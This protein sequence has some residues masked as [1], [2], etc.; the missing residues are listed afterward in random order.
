[1]KAQP[2]KGPASTYEQPYGNLVEL[3]TSS[4]IIDGVGLDLLAEVVGEYLDLLKSSA[5]VY[6][7]NGDYAL[8]IFASGWCRFLDQCSRNLCDTDD[9]RQA[10][11]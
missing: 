9:N 3:S 1:M 10:L 8:G 5:A 6:E 4:I 11:A 2:N 7:K